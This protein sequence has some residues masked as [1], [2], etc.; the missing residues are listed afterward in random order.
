MDK[1][2]TDDI[3]KCPTPDLSMMGRPDQC[4]L[5]EKVWMGTSGLERNR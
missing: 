2:A 4:H 3:G 1:G 5:P